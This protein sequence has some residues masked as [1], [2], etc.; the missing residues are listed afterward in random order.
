M[1]TV[2]YIKE[3]NKEIKQ[4]ENELKFKSN[5]EFKNQHKL[6]IRNMDETS[7]EE[8]DEEE[9]ENEEVSNNQE[10]ENEENEEEEEEEDDVESLD[11][12]NK[13]S[14][15]DKIHQ[16]HNYLRNSG[17][18]YGMEALKLFNLFYGLKKIEDSGLFDECG[19]KEECKFSY[20]LKKSKE[21]NEYILQIIDEIVLETL[22]KSK[23]NTL[24][25]YEIKKNSKANIFKTLLQDIHEISIIEKKSNILLSGKIYEYFIGR[26]ESAISELGAYFTDRHITKFCYKKVNP[27]LNQDGSLPTMIDMFG[28]S[29]G[30]TTEY[31][32]FMNEKYSGNIDWKQ[33]INNIFHYDINDD[34]LKSAGLE[35]FCLS[36][37]LPNMKDNIK[38]INSFKDIENKKYKYI[39]TNPPYG[40]DKQKKS[41]SQEKR[42]KIKE[43]IKKELKEIDDKIKEYEKDIEKE[44]KDIEKVKGKEKVKVEELTKLLEDLKA[45]KA[46]RV[47]QSSIINKKEKE[48][49]TILNNLNVNE[50]SC[51][52]K[53]QEFCKKYKLKCNDKESCSLI[54]LM[55]TV[56]EDGCVVGVLKEGV[57]FNK[58]Y[59]SLRKILVENYNVKEVISIDSSQFE[60]TTTKTSILI[61]TNTKEKTSNIVFSDLIVEKYEEDKIEDMNGEICIIENKGDIKNVYDK[62][63]SK[64]SINDILNHPNCSLNGKDY[65]K[66]IIICGED[67]EL[68]KLGDICEF[69]PKSKRKASYGEKD[70]QYNFYTSSDK[71]QKCNISDYNEEC[72]I[73]GTGGVAN[74]KIDNCFSCS[75]DNF[76]LKSKN[77]IYIYYLILGKIELLSDGFT[78]SVIKHLSK[79][80]LKNI[81]IPIP[82]NPAK[83]QEWVDKISKPYNEKNEKQLKI[84]E[85][86][87]FI[88]NRI[89]DI[90]DNEDCE[91]VKLGDICE[92]KPKSKR[93]ASFGQ[94]TGQYNFYTSSEKVQKCDLADYNEE[95]LIIGTGG[96]ANIKIDNI[97]SCSADNLIL[98]TKNNRYLYYIFKGNMNLLIDGFTGSVL[99]HISK[100]YLSKIKI[101]IPKNKKLIEDLEPIFQ[102]IETL[103]NEVKIAEELY[104]QYIEELSQEVILSQ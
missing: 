92:I 30:F 43:Y 74:I 3:E 59:K 85:L 69:L 60:N 65:N 100:D 96:S 47:K 68:V 21:D 36:G 52:G 11:G 23:I 62:I 97:F 80:Y 93:N 90:G 87:T 55:N 2:K 37:V 54:L 58:N 19:L 4:E 46:K 5:S 88:Q 14:L 48:E 44:E 8:D 12:I 81:Q 67:Y 26:D 53:I 86:E 6:I 89:R 76:I 84:K 50:I 7:E 35:I 77:N 78:G 31:I 10:K 83:I 25:F 29:G 28:G 63:T 13:D 82:K 22:S 1:E 56:D 9:E 40:G 71:I 91:L 72:L 61:F 103:Q 38:N 66:K 101:K 49:K 45:I 20:L 73:I 104:K 79:D 98:K 64:A 75:A 17:A 39:F 102:E 51:G 32:N 95:C 33:N 70:G 24:L 42:S 99:K 34:V 94:T 27:S 57:F 15:R 16:I 18:G 41:Q